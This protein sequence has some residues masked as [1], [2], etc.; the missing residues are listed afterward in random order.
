MTE[1]TP[2]SSPERP[3]SARV[4]TE[5][6]FGSFNIDR[7]LPE[8]LV[9]AHDQFL[10]DDEGNKFVFRLQRRL[11]TPFNVKPGKQPGSSLYGNVVGFA[12]TEA[13]LK[14]ASGHMDSHRFLYHVAYEVPH[15]LDIVDLRGIFQ[16]EHLGARAVM[17]GVEWTGG[18]PPLSDRTAQRILE[19][20]DGFIVNRTI[21]Q[22]TKHPLA[23]QKIEGED[24]QKMRVRPAWMML[25]TD[26]L[27]R[28][29]PVAH[30]NRKEK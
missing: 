22:K 4:M 20:H 28:I 23:A 18:I 30:R 8:S 11:D 16:K 9:V 21:A 13:A 12:N 27:S 5:Q 7:T 2:D 3:D 29:E 17:A 14:G 24:G 26:A 15:E 10:T 1:I 6:V 25:S 19:S